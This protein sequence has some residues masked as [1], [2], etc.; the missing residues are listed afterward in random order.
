MK[1]FQPM[2]LDEAKKMYNAIKN[3][4]KGKKDPI[5]KILLDDIWSSQMD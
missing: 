2:S 3:D 1:I 5:Y 4:S